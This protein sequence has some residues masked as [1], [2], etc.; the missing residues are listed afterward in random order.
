MNNINNRHILSSF[1]LKRAG[2]GMQSL[3]AMDW[4]RRP[5]DSA[6]RY[7]AR[8]TICALTSYHESDEPSCGA[9][10]S[11]PRIQ[12]RDFVTINTVEAT[13]GM[14]SQILFYGALYSAICSTVG[15]VE[16]WNAVAVLLGP[17]WSSSY[18]MDWLLYDFV[19]SSISLEDLSNESFKPTVN[20]LNKWFPHNQHPE[21]R[22]ASERNRMCLCLCAVALAV[23]YTFVCMYRP[24]ASQVIMK[25]AT[26][27]AKAFLGSLPDVDA[28]NL[29]QDDFSF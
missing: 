21:F 26:S 24:A 18:W 16:G 11:I 19:R 15:P 25:Q 10:A 14:C 6:G 22:L 20:L 13:A 23:T 1:S 8:K 27:V 5:V 29:F 17:W 28:F 2:T 4:L 12:Q 7:F 3:L 9:L